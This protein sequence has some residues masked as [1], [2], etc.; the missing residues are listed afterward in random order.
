LVQNSKHVLLLFVLA[1]KDSIANCHY[2]SCRTG[3]LLVS[4]P[5]L[6]GRCI[7]HWSGA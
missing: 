3:C 6:Q 2:R 1:W 5:T 4:S 7:W